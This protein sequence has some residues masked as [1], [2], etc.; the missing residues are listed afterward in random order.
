MCSKCLNV[1]NLLIYQPIS[2]K[3][4]PKFLFEKIFHGRCTTI[5]CCLV[6]KFLGPFVG[7]WTVH[8]DS[9]VPKFTN[10]RNAPG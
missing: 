7:F 10:C 3:F 9:G 5:Q 1:N 4:A 6:L 8:F 2:K